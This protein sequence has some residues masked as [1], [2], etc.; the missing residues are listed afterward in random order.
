MVTRKI[1]YSLA[2]RFITALLTNTCGLFVDSASIHSRCE[3][4][5]GYSVRDVG[6]K[7]V[8]MAGL[9]CYAF[10]GP[11]SGSSFPK[12]PQR[13]HSVPLIHA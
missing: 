7:S 3:I 12:T 8:G 10:I 1:N 13:P 11:L 5:G 9:A 4:Q 6:N 2:I